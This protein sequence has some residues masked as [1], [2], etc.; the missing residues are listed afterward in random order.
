M[1]E[2]KIRK[3]EERD[4]KRYKE[5]TDIEGWNHGQGRILYNRYNLYIILYIK[6]ILNIY[7]RYV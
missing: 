2:W 5:L 6:N 7:Y 1:T 3:V 4:L